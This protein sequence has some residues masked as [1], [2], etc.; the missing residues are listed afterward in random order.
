M[1]PAILTIRQIAEAADGI[2]TTKQVEEAGVS[3][4]LLKSLVEEGILDKESRG[5][6]SLADYFTD[7]Y[8]VIQMRSEIAIFSYGT[9][10]YLLGLSDRTPHFFDVSVP[11]GFR[12]VYGEQTIKQLSKELTSEF[13]KGFSRSNLQNMRLF[14]LS[15]ENCQSVTGKLSWTH[16]CES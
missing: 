13:G 9:A 14:Y 15:Y 8:K 4:T 6:Y 16:Y 2:V 12:A 1:N 7:E 10:L 3:R 11:Q 5:I